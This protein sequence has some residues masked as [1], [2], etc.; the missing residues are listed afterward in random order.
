MEL[1]NLQAA[2]K[3][4][5]AQGFEIIGISGDETKADLQRV[6]KGSKIPWRQVFDGAEGPINRKYGI[7]AIPTMFLIGRDGKIAAVNPQGPELE[8]A[9]RKALAQKVKQ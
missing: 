6:V 1:P 7:M 4:Y 5:K 3:K 9:I 2:Y 8:P